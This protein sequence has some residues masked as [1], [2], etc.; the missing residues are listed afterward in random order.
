M[1]DLT[2]K[3]P[4]SLYYQLQAVARRDNRSITDVLVE[5]FFQNFPPSTLSQAMSVENE[6]ECS[7]HRFVTEWALHEDWVIGRKN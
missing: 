2:L 5:V 3:L 1:I 7:E 4:E 6:R